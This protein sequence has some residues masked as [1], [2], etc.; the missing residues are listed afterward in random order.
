MQLTEF[1]QKI[2]DQGWA[3]WPEF[4]SASE[5]LELQSLFASQAFVP[6]Q[7]GQGDSL[8]R[9]PEIRGDETFWLDPHA[10]PPVMVPL[11]QKVDELRLQL[12]RRLFLGLGEWEAHLARYAPGTFY[13]KHVDRHAGTARRLFSLILYLNPEWKKEE[14][15]DL[16][17]YNKSNEELSRVLPQG[18]T[19]VGFL[20]EDFPHEV[21]V[22]KRERRSLTGWFLIGDTHVPSL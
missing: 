2:N 15:G 10:L 18:G 7:V 20:S 9:R 5:V 22:A 14:G 1:T 8:K 19:L 17:L 12:N 13:K 6:A 3:L 16:V 11:I 4:C 21:L